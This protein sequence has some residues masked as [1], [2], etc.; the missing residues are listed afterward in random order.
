MR[1]ALIPLW[2][3]CL[4]LPTPAMAQASGSFTMPLPD[5]SLSGGTVTVKVTGASMSEK[6]VGTQVILLGI[7]A[8][9]QASALSKT[10]TGKDGRAMFKDLKAGASYQLT[11]GGQGTQPVSGI[12]TGPA[13]GGLRF[14]VSLGGA[15]P[16]PGGAMGAGGAS[17]GGGGGSMPAGHPPTSGHGMNPA[18]GQ[19][20]G[21][22]EITPTDLVEAVK[23]LVRVVKGRGKT[24]VAGAIVMITADPT[25]AVT[26]GKLLLATPDKLKRRTDDKGEVRMDLPADKGGAAMVLAAHDEL[27]YRSR[28]L[29]GA[30]DKGL[31]VTFQVFDRTSDKAGVIFGAGTQLVAQVTEGR[32]SFMQVLRLS[33]TGDSIYDPG[34]EGLDLPLPEG[35]SGVEFPAEFKGLLI[36]DE[37]KRELRFLA[38]LPPGELDLRYFFEVSFSS[39]ETEIIQPLPLACPEA[40]VSVVNKFPVKVTGPSVTGSGM[41]EVEGANSKPRLVYRL[42]KQPAGGKWELTLSGLP[43]KDERGMWIVLGLAALIILWGVGAAVAGSARA[44]ARAQEKEQLLDRLA[45]SG[46][47]DK[48]ETIRAR[49]RALIQQERT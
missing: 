2:L 22:A 32:I 1:R 20:K 39:S 26:P 46:D 33:N 25:A 42:G 37:D 19:G 18:Q 38:P 27:T 4:L 35:A 23:L 48:A 9:S 41:R 8:E 10:T 21:A 13:E 6:M 44:R 28:P 43:A 14:L 30:K 12:F 17:P 15:N 5:A 7:S 34:K 40:S 11:L 29:S 3:L 16:M 36:T 24:P 45:R 31:L 47:G 49:L